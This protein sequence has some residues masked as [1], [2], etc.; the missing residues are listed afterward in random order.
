M[1]ALSS[2]QAKETASTEYDV[3]DYCGLTLGGWRK[4]RK[5]TPAGSSRVSPAGQSAAAP[6]VEYCCFG[7]RFAAAVTNSRGES[8]HLGWMLARLGAAIFFTLNVMVFSMALWAEDLYELPTGADAQ[9]AAA[10][11]GIYRYAALLFATPVLFLLGKPLAANALDGVRRMRITMDA[12]LLV[13]V[14]AAV[15]ISLVSAMLGAGPIYLDAACMI[16]V[17]VA[18]GR[19]LEASGRWKTNQALEQ[20]TSELPDDALVLQSDGSWQEQN[21]SE[22]PLGAVIRIAPGAQIP[23]DCVI[24]S[25]QASVDERALTGEFQPS[26][27]EAGDPVFAGSLNLDGIL[28]ARVTADAS[29]GAI[30][31]IVHLVQEARRSRSG[32]ER[33]ADRLT[34]WFVPLVMGL[35]VITFL[36]QAMADSWQQAFLASLAVLVVACPCAL[37]LATPLA[38]SAAFGQ[39][40]RSQL[41]FRDASVLEHLAKIKVVCFDKTGTLTTAEPRVEGFFT[42][43][44]EQQ[45]ELLAKAAALTEH[46]PHAY[47]KAIHEFAFGKDQREKQSLIAH[48]VSTIAGRGVTGL[49]GN[50]QVALGNELCMREQGL[51]FPPEWVGNPAED[52]SISSATRVFIGWE[53][54]VRGEFAIAETTRQD[55]A[56][57]IWRLRELDIDTHMLTGDN[58]A[59]AE[60]LAEQLGIG[61]DAQL[62][63]DEKLDVLRSLR[64]THGA[65]AMVGDGV[66]DAPALAAADVGFALACGTDVSRDSAD[67][68]VLNDALVRVPEAISLAR[69]TMR[70]VKQN[71]AWT[72]VYNTIAL[73]FAASGYLSPVLATLAMVGSSVFVIANS[74]RLAANVPDQRQPRTKDLTAIEGATL[75]VSAPNETNSHPDGIAAEAINSI[76]ST[77]FAASAASK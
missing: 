60:V 11:H 52:G 34:H 59:R 69:R 68:C 2:D 7:C 66:N 50:I 46:I 6:V 21:V 75:I 36:A 23:L 37:A 29:G 48:D 8:G 27:K 43:T 55:A 4:Q 39:A 70:I 49:I 67:V 19:F 54:C 61:F 51:R 65:V 18:V 14:A 77:P 9:S 42:V 63:P 57:S 58:P 13:G 26:I 62:L 73:C 31:R 17:C 47:S 24:L 76:D 15:G 44:V 32:T 72:I 64:A 30:Q 5:A 41:L 74:T 35:A 16:L 25:G 40:A 38:I 71:F 45:D 53:G 33:L 12:F 28:T 56:D 1:T 22:I 3:C 20:L 10:L